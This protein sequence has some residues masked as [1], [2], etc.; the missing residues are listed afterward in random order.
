MTAAIVDGLKHLARR[1]RK[2]T[3]Y[4]CRRCGTSVD[5]TTD[6]CPVCGCAEIARYDL[7]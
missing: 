3:I 2:Q 4:E 1:G 6:R 7:R 5:H